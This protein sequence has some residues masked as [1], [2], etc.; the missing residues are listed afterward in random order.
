MAKTRNAWVGSTFMFGIP[1]PGSAVLAGGTPR[2]NSPNADIQ[3]P[4]EDVEQTLA[5]APQSLIDHVKKRKT[6]DA[7]K[8]K[9]G[10]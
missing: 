6:A 8:A 4:L 1:D 3:E 9:G 5:D 10:K 7:K 2:R